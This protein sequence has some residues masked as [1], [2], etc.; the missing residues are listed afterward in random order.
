MDGTL[1]PDA[2][3]CPALVSQ[4]PREAPAQRAPSSVLYLEEKSDQQKK[5]EVG[6]GESWPWGEHGVP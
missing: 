4:A 5:E 2:C 6:E 3:S 1:M